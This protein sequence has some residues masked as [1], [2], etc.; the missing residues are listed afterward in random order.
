M[1]DEWVTREIEVQDLLVHNS[2][3]REGAGDLMPGNWRCCRW[4]VA[5]MR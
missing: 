2:G 3:L 5:M 4:A 1:H